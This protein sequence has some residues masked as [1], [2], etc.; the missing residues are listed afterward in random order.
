MKKKKET[1]IVFLVGI[2]DDIFSYQVGIKI[3][4]LEK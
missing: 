3:K 2:Q 4:L 1:G